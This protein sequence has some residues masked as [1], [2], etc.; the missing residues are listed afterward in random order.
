MKVFDTYTGEL[1][2]KNKAEIEKLTEYVNNHKQEFF[3]CEVSVKDIVDIFK[4]VNK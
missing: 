1:V 2:E 3:D 4:E